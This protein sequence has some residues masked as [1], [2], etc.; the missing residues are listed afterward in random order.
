[1]IHWRSLNEACSERCMV[2]RA[3]CT[4]V[5]STRSMN[6]AAHTVTSVHHCRLVSPA[7]PIAGRP[8]DLAA[9]YALLPPSGFPPVAVRDARAQVSLLVVPVSRT[10]GARHA[11]PGRPQQGHC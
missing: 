3:T 9:T 1:M 6:V 4:M 8:S 7:P 2:G 5:M 10:D 11:A